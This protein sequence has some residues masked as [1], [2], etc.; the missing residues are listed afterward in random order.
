[1]METLAFVTDIP[2][3]TPTIDSGNPVVD[4]IA[5]GSVPPTEDSGS[6]NQD[7]I[8][9][10]VSQT[11]APTTDSSNPVQDP[12]APGSVP[13]TTDS[14]NPIQD[15]IAPALPK[16]GTPTTDSGS[17][18]PIAPGSPAPVLE[19]P[20]QAPVSDSKP[21]ED[22][23]SDSSAVDNERGNLSTG[24]LL[25]IIVGSLMT[26]LIIGVSLIQRFQQSS[27]SHEATDPA[28]DLVLPYTADG[29]LTPQQD[30]VLL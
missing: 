6:P 20:T 11:G 25:A 30:V 8:A 29:I 18:D 12:I 5:P 13:P 14:S 2:T 19:T 28:F 10:G 27:P 1:M 9:P 16:T 22:I 24:A 26:V 15:P 7:P 23:E 21:R 4:P 3:P 17:Q